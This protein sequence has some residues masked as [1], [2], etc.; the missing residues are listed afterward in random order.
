MCYDCFYFTNDVDLTEIPML[1]CPSCGLFSFELLK[2]D[3]E[4]Q[5]G[6]VCVKILTSSVKPT[7]SDLIYG[8]GE[9]GVSGVGSPGTRPLGPGEFGLSKVLFPDA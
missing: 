6:D 7:S 9:E 2:L 1:T 5:G 3:E 4:C 8:P